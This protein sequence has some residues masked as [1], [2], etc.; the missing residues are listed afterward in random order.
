[1]SINLHVKT[2]LRGIHKL[3]EFEIVIRA[4]QNPKRSDRL[5][6]LERRLDRLY[7][8]ADDLKRERDLIIEDAI[9][10]ETEILRLARM[11]DQS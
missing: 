3:E 1:M 8:K 10:V 2:P 5:K 9:D 6:H 4:L 7:A 11:E